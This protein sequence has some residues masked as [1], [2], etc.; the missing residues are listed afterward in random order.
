VLPDSRI[1]NPHASGSENAAIVTISGLV[2]TYGGQQAVLAA[3]A[4]L[5]A[6]QN[7]RKLDE[8]VE[9]APALPDNSQSSPVDHSH[10]RKLNLM[11]E[12]FAGAC[13]GGLTLR[14]GWADQRGRVNTAL[15]GGT[16]HTSMTEGLHLLAALHR[17]FGAQLSEH[18]VDARAE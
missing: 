5:I 10:G 15:P 8:N 13:H 16:E 3:G 12:Q 14:C 2:L 17:W 6:R 18:G 4:G 7:D 11:L 9:E 1:S